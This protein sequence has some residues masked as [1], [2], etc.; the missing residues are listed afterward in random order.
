MLNFKLTINDV[1]IS[2]SLILDKVTFKMSS[3]M[4]DFSVGDFLFNI[5]ELKLHNDINISYG[6]VIRITIDDKPYGTYE[7]YDIKQ[8]DLY[9]EVELYA[10]P[11]LTLMKQY[12]PLFASSQYN[13]RSLLIEMATELNI[14]IHD[15]EN[16]PSVDMG[17]IASDTGMN[18]LSQIGTCMAKNVFI[19]HS[20]E[21]QF[22]LLGDTHTISQSNITSITKGE[23]EYRIT[24]V[25]AKRESSDKE[26]IVVGTATNEW[27]NMTITNPYLT[28]SICNNILNVL[29]QIQYYG[30]KLKIF[31]FNPSINI[32]DQLTFTY[33]NT[34]YTI[35][36]MN[37]NLTF[38]VGGMVCEAESLVSNN[39]AKASQFKGS[40]SSKLEVVQNLTSELNT[41][42]EVVDG[43]VSSIITQTD[44]LTGRVDGVEDS[45]TSITDRTS[46]VEQN[47]NS[48]TTRVTNTETS[49]AND[50]YT[51]NETISQIEQT[52][53]S[54]VQTVVSEQVG[55][56]TVGANNFVL[57]S[58]V[59]T[60]L[61]SKQTN[62]NTKY[63]WVL[64]ERTPYINENCKSETKFTL[65]IW[66]DTSTNP[67]TN[68]VIGTRTISANSFTIKQVEQD[69]FRYTYTFTI[70]VDTTL[71]NEYT[72]VINCGGLLG[73]NSNLRFIQ[74]EE[75]SI[76][77]SY[78]QSLEDV[79][80]DYN[81]RID[82]E[83]ENIINS[84][85]DL[86]NMVMQ[87]LSDD[88]ISESER[89]D[90]ILIFKEISSAHYN[91]LS[92]IES[93]DSEDY[94]SS[95]VNT[96]KTNYQNVND[97]M[98]RILNEER[99]G[100]ADFLNLL[101]KYYDSYHEVLFIISQYLKT[102]HEMM[103]TE[104]NQLSDRIDMVVT[105]ID[106]MQNETNKYMRF[107]KDGL[108]L[109]TTIN[110]ERGKFMTQ[111]SENRISFF[112]GNKEVAY[113]SN[114]KLYIS[115]AE[116]TTELKIGQICGRRSSSAGFVFQADK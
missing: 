61:E 57:K 102:K 26:P 59:E 107:S 65:S 2:N 25:T 39:N 55:K 32:L 112:E 13:T 94:F 19:N 70:Q 1:Q 75:G 30:F 54:I 49:L 4:K 79:I 31:N 58:N 23:S 77:S 27:N 89:G 21:V 18:L 11:V 5:V 90:L 24:S 68:V 6:D 56:I 108:Q 42:V 41:K 37:M 104:I 46:S 98:Y 76:P 71:S 81:N 67:F 111:I 114:E 64:S 40:F 63:S 82:T 62:D 110:G 51:K 22:K 113:V 35:P 87:I 115:S 7:P 72:L 53:E 116:I 100:K 105:S 45:I 83:I 73:C 38:G 78:M 12:E 93:Y 95:F 84:D 103:S 92:Q 80:S 91:L 109:F 88:Y 14:T 86:Q 85:S 101:A 60:H 34:Q 28:N 17:V 50:Y 52:S 99:T 44:V 106:D 20:G 9:R 29:S 10:M 74:L 36:I 3:T 48:I 33:K 47:L 69:L 16:I 66:L 96:L 8:K 43:Q 97:K 15:L